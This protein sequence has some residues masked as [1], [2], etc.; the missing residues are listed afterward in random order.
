MAPLA[1]LSPRGRLGTGGIILAF[2]RTF[3]L[4]CLV[5]LFAALMPMVRC[6]HILLAWSVLCAGIRRAHDIGR[7]FIIPV[8]AFILFNTGA[9]LA[10]L[11]A[12]HAAFGNDPGL[13]PTFAFSC[14]LPGTGMGLWLI[15]ATA[16]ADS[17]PTD[18]KERT[19]H[20]T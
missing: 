14:G 5:E 20:D 4:F 8:T 17:R 15:F 19:R 1:W 6:L 10:I 7:T 3:G 9:V 11:G 18:H 12:L 16:P 13:L 2:I